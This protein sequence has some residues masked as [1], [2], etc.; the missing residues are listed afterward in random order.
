MDK[1]KILF[2]CLGNICRSPSAEAVMKALVDKNGIGSRF[3]ID[4]AGITGYHAGEPADQR[5]QR[6]AINRN[7]RLTSIS[8]QVKSPDDFEYFD[9]IIGMDD[10]NMDDLYHLSPNDTSEK[11]SKMT[12]YCTQHSNTSVP[13]PYYGGAAGF[14]LVLDILEDA[15]AGLLNHIE[16]DGQ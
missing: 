5:M 2:V 8:R 1:T 16:E 10:Q 15:C 4:S 3:E 7:I 14:E 9:Y 12:D 6:H 13:D 11:I